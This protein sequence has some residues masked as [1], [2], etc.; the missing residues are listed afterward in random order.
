MEC[1]SVAPT[2]QHVTKS[3]KSYPPGFLYL[4][5]GLCKLTT[6][7]IQKTSKLKGILPSISGELRSHP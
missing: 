3:A 7:N 1:L 6:Y 2:P 5:T 4:C